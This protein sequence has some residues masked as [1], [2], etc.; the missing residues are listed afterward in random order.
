MPGDESEIITTTHGHSG[1]VETITTTY[2]GQGTESVEIDIAFFV[3][4][5][6]ECDADRVD[7]VK[8]SVL[9]SKLEEYASFDSSIQDLA[10]QVNGI[11]GAHIKLAQFTKIVEIWFESASCT[12]EQ[13]LGLDFM[14]KIF[15]DLDEDDTEMATR[16][17]LRQKID[18]YV[19]MDSQLQQLSD[20]IRAIDG[21][22]V[23]RDDYV[24]IVE[25]WLASFS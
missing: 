19:P 21:M 6:E 20:K 15:D 17:D 24:E 2:D 1:G 5:F 14:T 9:K 3:N 13:K 7:C 25:E 22:I 8:K 23:E 11:K 16:L 18:E 4:M 12:V 10:N